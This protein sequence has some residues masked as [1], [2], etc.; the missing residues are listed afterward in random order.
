MTSHPAARSAP[1]DP[2]SPARCGF[3]RLG[4]AF[5]ACLAAWAGVAAATASED[6]PGDRLKREETAPEEAL[7]A[8]IESLSRTIE[9]LDAS[10][11][12][13]SEE[14]R[15]LRRLLETL[16]QRDAAAPAAPPAAVSLA[17]QAS[18]VAAGRAVQVGAYTDPNEAEQLAESLRGKGLPVY[19]AEGEKA[20]RPWWRVRVGPFGSAAEAE[21]VAARLERDEK[22]ATWVVA[23]PTAPAAEPRALAS[24]PAGSVPLG[25]PDPLAVQVGAYLERG[26]AEGAAESL[27]AKG[28]STYV[29]RAAKAGPTRWRV[30]VGPL[31][32]REEAEQ[33]AHHLATV[34]RVATWVVA[35][36][37]PAAPQAPAASPAEAVPPPRSLPAVASARAVATEPEPTAVTTASQD[38]GAPE[39]VGR[40]REKERPRLTEAERDLLEQRGGVLVPAGQLV[41]EPGLQYSNFS[42]DRLQVTGFA[43]LPS[44]II[45]RL[46]TAEIERDVFSSFLVSRYG[47]ANRLNL[48]VSVPYLY[49]RDERVFGAEGSQQESIIKDNGIG[50]LSVG[51]FGHVLREKRWIPDVVAKLGWKFRN[52]RDPFEID[53]DPATGQP[54]QLAFGTGFNGLSGGFTATKAT[55]PAV[56]FASMNYF[57]HIGRDV[58]AIGDID[59]GDVLEYDLGL[60]FGLNERLAL[61]FSLQHRILGKTKV[62]GSSILRT[63]AN[64]ATLFVGSS[65]RFSPFFSTNLS[66]GIGITD[67]APDFLVE[68]RVPFRIPYRF[69]SLPLGELA[70]AFD[71]LKKPQLFGFLD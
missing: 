39:P 60:A 35:E 68:F 16:A 7:E 23:A 42:R 40:A 62:N 55:D 61:S 54:T 63:D 26:D 8:R 51:L 71:N 43:L 11:H 5:L 38:A 59:P 45:G 4:G 50:D 6:S 44:I 22:L 13:A 41:L 66:L 53:V 47:L 32:S 10:Q 52:G 67:D 24:R 65:Y 58:G 46:D 27:R 9:A 15:A 64:S 21:R 33:V 57:W 29:T 14:I 18:P 69:P 70:S 19:L 30:R 3:L 1:R 49:R 20:G 37:S 2:C 36:E 56:L 34:E 28:F 12:A 48:D 31:A 17:T 25:S